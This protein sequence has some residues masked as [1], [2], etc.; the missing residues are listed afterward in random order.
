M[1][2]EDSLIPLAV[3]ASIVGIVWILVAGT[4]RIMAI[5]TLRE[6]ART[7]PASLETIAARLAAPP[8]GI[9]SETLGL[10]GMAMG[11]ALCVAGLIGDAASRTVLI[12]TALLPGFMGAALFGQRWLP[13]RTPVQPQLPQD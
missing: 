12:Q 5:R 6:T 4:V 13:G 11:A 10:L 7:S 3:F 2:L 9:R 1:L 8:T